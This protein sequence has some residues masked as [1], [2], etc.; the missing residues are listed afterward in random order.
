M[1][2]QP[3]TQQVRSKDSPV[4]VMPQRDPHLVLTGTGAKLIGNAHDISRVMEACRDH[5]RECEKR[6]STAEDVKTVTVPP[7]DDT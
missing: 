7:P 5:L 3:V 4:A 1:P 6:P 2:V